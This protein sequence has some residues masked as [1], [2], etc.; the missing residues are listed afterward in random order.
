MNPANDVSWRGVASAL[1][2]SYVADLRAWAAKLVAGYGVAVA[3]LV[4][5]VLTL[6]AAI[7]VGVT[8]LF[9][10]VESHYGGD[11]AYG[12]IGGGLLIF[13]IVLVLVGWAMLRRRTPPLPRPQR[14][15]EAARRIFLT[16]CIA[17]HWLAGWSGNRGGGADHQ[18]VHRRGCYDL[19]G[20]DRV[21]APSVLVSKVSRTAVSRRSGLF[22]S[23]LAPRRH[24]AGW[25][26]GGIVDI[27]L[28]LIGSALLS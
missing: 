17:R 10:L 8:A 20:M 3:M 7:A 25:S 26:P 2:R 5:G 4:G 1:V 19:G 21:L 14:Q 11:T 6:F 23:D 28:W 24:C 13:A 18:A 22:A 15:V 16:H 9:H 12:A 27:V